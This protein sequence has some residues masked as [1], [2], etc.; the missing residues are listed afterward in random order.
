MDNA[1]APSPQSKHL[2]H[3]LRRELGADCTVR[4]YLDDND[5]SSVAIL[6]ARDVPHAGA[7]TY[8]TV[9]L[10]DHSIGM[11]ANDLPLRVELV[12]AAA[13]RFEHA[14]NMLATSAFNII[15][16]GWPAKPGETHP[17]VVE[18]YVPSSELK[19]VLLT[20]PYTRPLAGQKFAGYAVAWL[21]LLPISESELRYLETAGA[22][23]LER[24]LEEGSVNTLDLLRPPVV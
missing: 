23:A 16:S 24:R 7:S 12:L 14:P 17:G 6:T 10:S 15:N 22:D 1:M 4:N 18:M 19:H 5:R 3:Y 2:A 9:D 11:S 21:E 20:A 8:A 13:T